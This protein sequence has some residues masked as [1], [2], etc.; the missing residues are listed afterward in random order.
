[1]L[2]D[3]PISHARACSRDGCRPA[4]RII[5]RPTAAELSSGCKLD[6]QLPTASCRLQANKSAVFILQQQQQSRA[7]FEFNGTA[8]YC[9]RLWNRQHQHKFKPM[10]HNWLTLVSLSSWFAAFS[11]QG[12]PSCW[13]KFGP[14][15]KSI[16]VI[17]FGGTNSSA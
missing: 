12:S 14:T 17:Q 10:L 6:F 7:L 4:G 8:G 5:S 13:L 15:E 11:L 3:Q 2:A 16:R 1:M 9:C